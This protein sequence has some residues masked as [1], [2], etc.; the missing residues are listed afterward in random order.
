V[1]LAQPII[2]VVVVVA[3]GWLILVGVRHRV[4]LM[5][6]AADLAMSALVRRAI[7]SA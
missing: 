4:A 6:L 7:G 3:C 5:C 2:Q 1:D